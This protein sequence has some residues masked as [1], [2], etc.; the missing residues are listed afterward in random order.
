MNTLTVHKIKSFTHTQK[1][2]ADPG[3][4]GDVLLLVTHME[5][6]KKKNKDLK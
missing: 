5:N 2:L 4:N 6:N 3:D 1:L